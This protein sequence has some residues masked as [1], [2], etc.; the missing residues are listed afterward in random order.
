MV[1]RSE[2]QSD[3]QDVL[4]MDVNMVGFWLPAKTGFKM[5]LSYIISS[6]PPH[7]SIVSSPA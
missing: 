6:D 1:F 3:T 2:G 5:W 7:P 4:F